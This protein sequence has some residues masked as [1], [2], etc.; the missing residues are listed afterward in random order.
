[1]AGVAGASLSAVHPDSDETESESE[2]ENET[3]SPSGDWRALD[4]LARAYDDLQASGLA[5]GDG[6]M[7][8]DITND[9][10]R[11]KRSDRSDRSDRSGCSG[12]REMESRST[13]TH[14]HL[15]SPPRS[16]VAPGSSTEAEASSA[17]STLTSRDGVFLNENRAIPVHPAR[18]LVKQGRNPRDATAE[19]VLDIYTD[20]IAENDDGIF[21][22]N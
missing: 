10:L 13:S 16:A 8:E 11:S 1:L 21:G 2:A 6:S 14:D 4:K 12:R 7:F 5:P 9:V 19:D 15:Q 20:Q 18:Y 22:S 17:T 3:I